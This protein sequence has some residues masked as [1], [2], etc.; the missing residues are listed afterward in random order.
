MDQKINIRVATEKDAPAMIKSNRSMALKTEG[1]HLE[2]DKIV[3]GVNA[4][5][6][7]DRRGFY[8]IE[9]NE[10]EEVAGGLI[11]SYKWSDRRNDRFWW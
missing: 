7:G 5:F 6:A 3:P 10:S 9:D 11:V 1:K 8:V 2:P 4:V